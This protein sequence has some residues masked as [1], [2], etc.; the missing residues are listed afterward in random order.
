MKLWNKIIVFT[1][2]LIVAGVFPSSANADEYQELLL[3]GAG[4]STNAAE[5]I[6]GQYE[7]RREKYG[8]TG[9]YFQ[10]QQEIW[11]A[12]NGGPVLD[13]MGINVF[14]LVKNPYAQ[15]LHL[16]LTFVMVMF[17]FMNAATPEAVRKGAG[18]GA[19]TVVANIAIR[20]LCGILVIGAP[21]VIYAA[22][23]SLKNC[24]ALIASYAI[25]G[26]ED[27][28]SGGKMSE[29][30]KERMS[31]M[32]DEQ[33][34]SYLATQKAIA[35]AV[36]DR[37]KAYIGDEPQAYQTQSGASGDYSSIM[38]AYTIS[39]LGQMGQEYNVRKKYG[40]DA[41][42]ADVAFAERYEREQ[43]VT[44]IKENMADTLLVS[45][46]LPISNPI[47]M[48]LPTGY[49]Y[50]LQSDGT[51]QYIREGV[52]TVDGD[53]RGAME[54][55][56]ESREELLQD[57]AERKAD[58]RSDFSGSELEQEMKELALSLREELMTDYYGMVYTT[59]I[60]FLDRTLG[61]Y[62]RQ[63]P[64]KG[65]VERR[66]NTLGSAKSNL[67]QKQ[68]ATNWTIETMLTVRYWTQRI[69]MWLAFIIFEAV[70]EISIV[71]L[72]MT[73]PLSFLDKTR[74]AF[75][76]R[77]RQ[78]YIIC[79][80]AAVFIFLMGAVE[81]LTAEIYAMMMGA[82]LTGGGLG[83]FATGLAFRLV[84]N[85]TTVG[86]L[87]FYIVACVL[88]LF[89]TPKI[90]QAIF[91]GTGIVGTLA[92][93]AATAAVAG[94]MAAAATATGGFSAVGGKAAAGGL[95]RRIG[96]RTGMGRVGDGAG[97]VANGGLMPGLNRVRTGGGDKSGSISKQVMGSAKGGNPIKGQQMAKD[98]VRG[99]ARSLS[100]AGKEIV[101]AVSSGGDF[102]NYF[103]MR[104][105]QMG[106]DRN[107]KS[108]AGEEDENPNDNTAK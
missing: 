98:V 70:I 93:G 11:E 46:T 22:A 57:Y 82:D 64:H 104:Q 91:R 28:P 73:Y 67:S 33:M 40:K 21:Q 8:A 74:P 108:G 31:L 58:I 5:Y 83:G 18:N 77:A 61:G 81:A 99:Q 29:R 107:R 3:E 53:F 48:Q 96:E 97:L 100:T 49:A 2:A 86:M 19:H 87:V 9:S 105:A 66:L 13:G 34:A 84:G 72:W 38:E 12:S 106:A 85:A 95:A 20:L 45:A 71:L 52:V 32:S 17:A 59:T 79:L 62:L 23:M 37:I 16:L 54:A 15:T 90:T 35:E 27:D 80:N 60:N 10:A 30:Y 92:Q 39:Y 89:M 4:I 55:A 102:S 51:K 14:A 44:Y 101:A 24:T 65:Y 63:T 36:R 43:C 88:C 41:F 69:I 26:S 94:G 6:T 47:T 50:T 75:N 7:K 1:I 68:D 42:E 78:I 56:Y 103:N 76:G 25:S